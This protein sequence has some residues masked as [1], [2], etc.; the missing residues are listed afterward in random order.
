MKYL[1]FNKIPVKYNLIINCLLTLLIFVGI[2]CTNSDQKSQAFIYNHKLSK[3]EVN[4]T[5]FREW[6]DVVIRDLFYEH[7]HLLPDGV[8]LLDS[9]FLNNSFAGK[10]NAYSVEIPNTDL[11]VRIYH[12]VLKDLSPKID[13]GTYQIRFLSKY[14]KPFSFVFYNKDGVLNIYCLDMHIRIF[15]DVNGVDLEA[16]IHEIINKSQKPEEWSW[17]LEESPTNFP[18]PS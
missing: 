17:K 12:F 11:P 13:D 10:Y 1:L 6:S 16:L 5:V 3:V 2:S 7:L 14:V 9:V 15:C 4:D 18:F 8:S